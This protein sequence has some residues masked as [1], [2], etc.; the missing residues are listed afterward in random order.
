MQNYLSLLENQ[1]Y[2][3]IFLSIVALALAIISFLFGA[4]H[5]KL[6]MKDEIRRIREESVKKSRAVTAG[7]MGE[8]V[9]PFLPDFPCNPADV[10][11]VGKPIDFVGF[12]GSSAG[13]EISEVLLIE[14][15][16]GNS[17]LSERERQIKSAV[18]NGRVRY[19]IYHAL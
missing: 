12:P 3:I 9:A 15:K 18:E 17:T 19:V 14:V 2:F 1:N 4:T 6:S 13:E 8:Q 7:L 11:F 10:R 5:A 16:T